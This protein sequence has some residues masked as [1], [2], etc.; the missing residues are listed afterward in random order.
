MQAMGSWGCLIIVA[1]HTEFLYLRVP[2]TK[3]DRVLP[4]LSCR[5]NKG[6]VGN[7]VTTMV[8]NHY[9]SLKKVS[10][11]KSSNQTAPSLK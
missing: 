8:H 1:V 7:C 2:Q 3:P 4:H 6:A 10:P 9:G 11:P 5:S